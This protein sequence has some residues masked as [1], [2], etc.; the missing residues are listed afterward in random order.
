MPGG[1]TKVAGRLLAE[2]RTPTAPSADGSTSLV[3]VFHKH[4]KVAA[5]ETLAIA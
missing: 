4:P 1:S 5:A 2:E 3:A